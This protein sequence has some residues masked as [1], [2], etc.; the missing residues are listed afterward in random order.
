MNKKLCFDGLAAVSGS[1]I[2]GNFLSKE[3]KKYYAKLKKLYDEQREQLRDASIEIHAYTKALRESQ[4]SAKDK[5]G[6]GYGDQMNKSVLSYENEVFQSVFVNKRS[7]IE[8]SHVN[9]RYADGM[10]AVPP[11]MTGIYIPSGPNKEID[12]SQFTYGPKQ[13]KPSESDARS[14]D[15]NSCESNC[16]EETH[17]SMS[18]PVINEPKVVSEPKV[19]SDAPIIEE[20]K[21]DSEDKHVSLPTKE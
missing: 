10:H 12:D 11:P 20:Y 19:W 17:E 7:D 21:S 15:F 3:C 6:L 14:N 1:D 9:D 2:K 18:E 13:S 8:D 5:A 16:S 4:M